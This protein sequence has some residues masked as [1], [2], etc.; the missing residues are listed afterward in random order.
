MKLN[1]QKNFRLSEAEA[2]RLSRAVQQTGLTESQW[3]RLMVLAALGES[4]LAEHL[5]RVAARPRAPKRQE[6]RK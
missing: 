5:T 1:R 3:L 2:K 4:H 6:A